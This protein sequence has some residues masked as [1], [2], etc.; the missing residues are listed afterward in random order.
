MPTVQKPPKEILQA[1]KG[2]G[3][4]VMKRSHKQQSELRLLPGK[5]NPQK[6]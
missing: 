3:I 4:A 5:W 2:I 1:Q 6:Y